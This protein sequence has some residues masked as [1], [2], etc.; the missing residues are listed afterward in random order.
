M[1]SYVAKVHRPITALTLKCAERLPQVVEK[2][3][4]ATEQGAA[5]TLSPNCSILLNCLDLL[6]ESCG[7]DLV[8]HVSTLC[9]FSIRPF[10]S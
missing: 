9:P 3:K 6:P 1:L 8:H 7:S 2:S 5:L 10:A 4:F